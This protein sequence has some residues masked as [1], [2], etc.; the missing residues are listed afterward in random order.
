MHK[1]AVCLSGHMRLFEECHSW[2]IRNVVN[3]NPEFEFDYFIHT[4]N[5]RDKNNEQF[6]SEN[7]LSIYEPTH[8][9]IE[10]QKHLWDMHKYLS[11][12]EVH[13]HSATDGSHVLFM[14][15]KMYKCHQLIYLS[16]KKYDLVMRTR[17]DVNFD[18][19]FDLKRFLDKDA[20]FL[21]CSG[22]RKPV[23]DKVT[24][25][26]VLWNCEDEPS[27]EEIRWGA[28][29]DQWAIGS[30]SLLDTYASAYQNIDKLCEK[31]GI[32]QP[33]AILFQHLHERKCK[34]EMVKDRHH[35]F[36]GGQCRQYFD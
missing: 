31:Y 33:E 16:N 1:I 29:N 26:K 12:P 21:S 10:Q 28:Y 8:V 13:I 32:F 20:I 9:V 4:W 19:P 18:D 11:L 24:Q 27:R 3:Y 30:P 25:T 22:S 36:R 35:L 17:P 15:Y 14:F 23:G 7:D 5:N 2:F 6:I 34:V